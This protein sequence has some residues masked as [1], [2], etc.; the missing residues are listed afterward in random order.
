[1]KIAH[2]SDPHINLQFH[3]SHLGRL[4]YVLED[5]LY[6]HG[7]DHIVITGDLTSNADERDLAACR[8]LFEEMGLLDPTK[9]SL[10]IG[11]HDI[12]GGPHLAQDLLSFPGKCQSNPYDCHIEKFHEVFREVFRGCY[13]LTE[14]AYPYLKRI[15]DVAFVGL[16][17]I[18]R[19]SRLGNPVGSNGTIDDAQVDQMKEL[20]KLA[21][22]AEARS[23]IVMLHH[24]FFRKKDEAQIHSY[25]T[26]P[27]IFNMIEQETL[28][29]RGKRK[30]LKAFSKA[31]ID[32]VLHGHVHFTGSYERK[33]IKF[34]NGA[35]AVHPLIEND[36]LS[37]N[38]LTALEGFCSAETILIPAER[39]SPQ[40]A[41]A[42]N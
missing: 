23:K 2:L 17:S 30:L 28:K 32:T 11:N 15:G 22:F 24:H 21:Q 40:L 38:L 5:A 16:N 10:V 6:A 13:R 9:L 39:R 29:L 8:G 14:S 7:A 26:G 37:Y 36:E 25:S 20:F 27:G 4:R 3:P 33:G 1:M 19:H 12:F 35:G 42:A 41:L 18:A 31:G 34:Y